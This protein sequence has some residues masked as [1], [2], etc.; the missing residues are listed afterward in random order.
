MSKIHLPVRLSHLLRQ[1]S[2]GAIVR[3]PK[4]LVTVTDTRGWV[5]PNGSQA[6]RRIPYVDQVRS[7]LGIEQELW[8]P[9]FAQ[10]SDTGQIDG[11]AVP[12]VRFPAWMVCP[13][14][15]LLHYSPWLNTHEEAPR[16]RN[17]KKNGAGE[18]ECPKHPELEQVAWVMIHPE[19]HMHEVPWHFIAHSKS[20]TQEQ[21]QCQ[22]PA[23][24]SPYL[25]LKERGVSSRWEVRCVVCGANAQ[26]ESKW[27]YGKTWRQP[28][29]KEEPTFSKEPPDMGEIVE[30]NDT[31]VHSALS[32][33]ALVIPPESRIQHGSIVD[34]LYTSTQ[35]LEQIQRARRGLARSN[36]IMSVATEFRCTKTDIEQA[37]V[38]IEKGYP[39][40]GRQF[41]PGTLAEREYAAFRE[42]IPDLADDED[43]VTTHQSTAWRALL[44][45]LPVGSREA[46]IVRVIDQ[47]IAVSRLKEILVLKGFTRM[48]S[49][50]LVPPDIVG[51]SRWLPALEL[52]G[53]GIFFNFDEALVKQ[54]ENNEG[55]R[56]RAENFVRRFEHSNGLVQHDDTFLVDARFILLHTI[57]HLAIRQLETLAGYPSSSLKE[58]IFSA[59]GLK[60]KA[61]ILIYVAVPDIAGSL[62]GLTELAEPKRFLKLMA[63]VFEHAEWCSLDPVCAEHEGQGPNQLN[64]AACHACALVPEP[65]CQYG[66]VLLDRS[67]IAGE[68]HCLPA[69]LDVVDC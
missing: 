58:R 21:K 24:R 7:A 18:S 42:E 64:R 67:F 44:D 50:T 68:G 46:K 30:V 1:C 22:G 57:A 38:E 39:L 51:E 12:A 37:L 59:G 27:H 9:P 32:V 56:A 61:G 60:P 25:K 41:T 28:W 65:S 17:D 45:S 55:V 11:V 16:C 4:Y 31:R 66:N 43:F 48:G 6:G 40:Y 54:W 36:H 29:L 13:N 49:T 5:G 33:S 3:G 69:L 26:L 19:G 63:K 10:K 52:Y 62:G 2:V 53:E 20:H 35:K 23:N 47:V 15:G 8:E 34:R 14:C